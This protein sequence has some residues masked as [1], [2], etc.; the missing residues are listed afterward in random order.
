MQQPSGMAR[1]MACA[2]MRDIS[3]T[4]GFML[5]AQIELSR[6]RLKLA[7]AAKFRKSAL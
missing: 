3:C 1:N 7:E 5:D 2:A 4:A 6:F